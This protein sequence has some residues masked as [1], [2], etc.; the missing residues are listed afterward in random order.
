MTEP[1]RDEIRCNECG[2]VLEER[3]D[4]PPEQRQPCPDCGSLSRAFTKTITTSIEHKSSLGVKAKSPSGTRRGKSG[5]RTFFESFAGDSLYRATGEWRRLERALDRANDWYTERVV[6]PVGE[7]L[8]WREHPLSEHWGHGGAKQY[9]G[10]DKI[11]VRTEAEWLSVH[12]P[13]DG[14]WETAFGDSSYVVRCGDCPA[15]WA[16]ADGLGKQALDEIRRHASSHRG[17]GI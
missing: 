12:P 1:P 17:A 10:E 15:V 2:R 13:I 16:G 5:E 6:T 8:R 7:L 3:S 14:G 4:I 9:T 11:V